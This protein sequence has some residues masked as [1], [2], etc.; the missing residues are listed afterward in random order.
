MQR[1]R[2]AAWGGEGSVGMVAGRRVTGERVE[3]LAAILA[4]RGMNRRDFLRM[5][6]A[7]LALLGLLGVGACGGGGTSGTLR[8]SMWSDTP[9]E[10][11][12][13]KDLAKDVHEKYSDITVK[14]ETVT[15]ADYWDKLTTQIASENEADIVAMQSLRMPG[16]AARGAL[17][18]LMPFI[19]D[20]S[21]F[22]IGDFFGPIRQ[23]LSVG[24]ELYALG[25]D[26]G[27]IILYYNKDLFSKAGVE[28]P[29]AETP[30][31]WEEFRE[32]AGQLTDP[33][34]REYGF[35]EQPVFDFM[36]PWLWSGGGGYMNAAQT[37]CTLDTPESI[38]AMEFVIGMI[39]DKIAAP[40][41]DLA[42]PSFAVEEFY[43]GKIGMHVDGPW[44]FIN[45][46]E[47]SDFEWDV[48]PMPAGPAGSV[49]WAAGSGFGIS[50]TTEN[51]DAAWTALKT[52]TSTGSLE[53]LVKAG[54]G[55][56]ARESAVSTFE[57]PPPQNVDVV[58]K[59]LVSDIGET[60]PFVT[61]TTWQETTVMLTRD[62]SPVF[63]GK[64]SV[65][66][67]VRKVKPQFDK[68]LEE[69]QEILEQ[70]S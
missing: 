39:T 2:I 59:I 52:I 58:Q 36:V 51:A 56:P 40:V 62:F 69:H 18:P 43:G 46:R 1:A 33:D 54:R 31:S 9:E 30:M 35:V 3:F 45:I 14:L 60:R 22:D 47:N 32:K 48:A 13:W 37:E 28:P 34:A 29:P 38:E 41:T 64:Q 17:Q 42:N 67:V 21:D 19:E 16:Y 8:W 50:N 24:D 11:R 68:L 27:P 25:Y 12:V 6:G 20:D 15:F 10:T 49:T 7:G 44:Q 57:K 70:Q 65:D 53:K 61:T 5:G 4:E 26:I 23:G 63:L 55:Y 66:A